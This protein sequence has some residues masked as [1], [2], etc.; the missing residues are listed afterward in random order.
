MSLLEVIRAGG[1]VMWPLAVCSLVAL[2]IIIERAINLR[3]SRILDPGIV[4]EEH[5]ESPVTR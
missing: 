4:V 1:A 3:A 2:A 5:L